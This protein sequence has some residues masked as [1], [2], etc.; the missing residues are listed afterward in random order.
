MVS[1]KS[2]KGIIPAYKLI[3]K[4]KINKIEEI[5]SRQI[6]FN[7]FIFFFIDFFYMRNLLV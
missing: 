3:M 2:F 4:K 6:Y 5:C 1:L 7:V